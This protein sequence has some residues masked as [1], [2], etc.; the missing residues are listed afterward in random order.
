MQNVAKEKK[1]GF[2]SLLLGTLGA[3]LLGSLLTGRGVKRSKISG[4]GVMRGGKC[5]IRAGEN[6]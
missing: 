4:Q 3:I 1:G 6:F 5:T 2:L